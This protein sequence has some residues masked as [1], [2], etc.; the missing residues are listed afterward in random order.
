MY[1]VYEGYEMEKEEVMA[2]AQKAR[3]DWE[4][5]FDEDD[6][7]YYGQFKEYFYEVVHE[8][9]FPED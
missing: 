1:E 6:Y 3:K 4:E 2:L 9:L 8:Y 7:E 5:E